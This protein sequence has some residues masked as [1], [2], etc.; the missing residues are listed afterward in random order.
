MNIDGGEK[1]AGKSR[2]T[3]ILSISAQM[4]RFVYEGMLG[5][6]GGFRLDESHRMLLCY[7]QHKQT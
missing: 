1:S 2:I 5:R 7:L 6:L 3:E 4:G